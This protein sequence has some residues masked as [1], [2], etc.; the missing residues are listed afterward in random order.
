MPDRPT[1]SVRVADWSR[2]E[3][4]IRRVRHIV[5]VEEQKVDPDEE[6]DEADSECLHVLAETPECDA[7]GTGRLDISGK[8]GRMAVLA[9]Y[10]GGGVGSIILASLLEKANDRALKEV[11]LHA[12]THAVPFY[13]RHG[14]EAEGEEFL[15]ANIPHIRMR[16]RLPK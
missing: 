1:I 14:F 11:Y 5:F 13:A 12:Q 15:E 10:R 16:R 7:V 9:A 8:I 4:A 2:D 3:A 6:W